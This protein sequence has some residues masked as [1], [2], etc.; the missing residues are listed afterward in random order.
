MRDGGNG[1][2]C[3]GLDRLDAGDDKGPKSPHCW[4]ELGRLFLNKPYTRGGPYLP[5][6][7]AEAQSSSVWRQ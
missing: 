5:N 6:F 4:M 7:A 3:Y 2:G 1:V